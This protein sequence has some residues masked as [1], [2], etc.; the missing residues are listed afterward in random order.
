MPRKRRKFSREF[1]AGVALEA[2]RGDS[3]INQIASEYKIHPNQV[4]KWKAQLLENLPDIF[5]VGQQK[6]SQNA[7]FE[8]ERDELY[9]QIG[10]LKVEM[11][12]LKK[13][14]KPF[15]TD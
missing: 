15:F 6:S 7:Q 14:T 12:W 1:K 10:Q 11:D 5:A 2:V 8:K 4:S 3:T 13:K 9:R